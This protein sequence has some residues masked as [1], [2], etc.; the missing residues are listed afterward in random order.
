VG[1]MEKSGGAKK[2]MGEERFSGVLG[3]VWPR[4]VDGLIRLVWWWTGRGRLAR[5]SQVR[6]GQGVWF[7]E[8]AQ[9]AT[10]M[11]VAAAGDGGG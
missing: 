4:V 10:V 6:S 9:Q 3:P 5:S 7:A 1:E 2:V 11:M 8:T